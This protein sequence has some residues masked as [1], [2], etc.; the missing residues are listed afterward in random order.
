MYKYILCVLMSVTCCYANEVSLQLDRE[1][2]ALN[3]SFTAQFTTNK[4]IQ[5]QPD[6]T[7]LKADF[8]ILSMNTAQSTTIYNG[9]Y[10]EETNWILH[11][12]PKR[13]G[14]L[15]IPA[16]TFGQASSLPKVLE[17]SKGEA[18]KQDEN[19]FIEV[20]LTP[21]DVV[22]VETP[23]I[24][25][26]RLYCALQLS[27]GTLS[28]ITTNNPDTLIERVGKDSQ[29][30]KFYKNGKR[31]I[32]V[33]RK[34][35]IV[36]ASPGE[37]VISPVVFEGSIM[38]RNFSMFDMQAD[39][40]RVYSDSQ[41]IQ[42]KKV[43]LNISHDKWFAANDVTIKEKFSKDIATLNVGE[44]VTWTITLT[45]DGALGSHIPDIE[46][47]SLKDFKFYVDKPEI[48]N[49][50]AGSQ[51]IGTKEIK[52]AVIPLKGGEFQ[53]PEITMEWWNIKTE[54]KN[55]AEL[56]SKQ[57]TV[58]GDIVA[59]IEPKNILENVDEVIS[60]EHILN[61]VVSS[62]ENKSLKTIATI[63]SIML[64]VAF[65]CGLIY[66]KTAKRRNASSQL[67]ILKRKFKK[68]CMSSDT[69]MAEKYLLA[70]S[71]L[72]FPETKCTNL[73]DIK[74]EF[75]NEVAYEIDV[76]YKAL[77]AVNKDWNGHALWVSFAAFKRERKSKKAIKDTT[78]KLEDLY[79]KYY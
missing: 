67:R 16:I 54:Q 47:V 5:G 79:P 21:P 57:V 9:K 35:M 10:T 51:V 36:P 42:V 30:E 72:M 27:H 61:E 64:T 28:E 20:E 41:K 65:I 31:Y 63:A 58:L 78:K 56:P 40:R 69:K 2:I 46:G 43:P 13:E 77:Y 37:L 39:F 59:M 70:S 25:T 12:M 60:N 66:I 45:A 71:R 14:K 53:L 3:E 26:V 32:V 18:G 62:H 7:P 73:M 34:Y 29:Y 8:E 17:V 23:L 19:I 68:A 76:L 49:D 22:Y 33:E 6:F 75:G 1:K 44:P 52:I 50:V 48:K 38:A 11:L 55:V 4:K 15:I 24:C 74:L